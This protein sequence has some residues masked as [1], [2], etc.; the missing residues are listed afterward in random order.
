MNIKVALSK[1]SLTTAPG[2]SAK[3]P[4]IVRTVPA[5]NTRLATL[6][7]TVNAPSDRTLV[8]VPHLRS[9]LAA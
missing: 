5:S 4:A 2:Y 8:N 3:P 1:D 9:Y 6:I 7:R